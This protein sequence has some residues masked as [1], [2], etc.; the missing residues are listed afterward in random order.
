MQ[1]RLR[2]RARG[3][4]ELGFFDNQTPGLRAIWWTRYGPADLNATRGGV[5]PKGFTDSPHPG[6]LG[7][8]SDGDGHAGL[9]GGHVWT[10]CVTAREIGMMRRGATS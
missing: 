10:G 8:P 3:H 9:R 2:L 5:V 1:R 4:G 7:S 6:R